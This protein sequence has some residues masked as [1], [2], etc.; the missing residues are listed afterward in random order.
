LRQLILIC[1]L[2]VASPAALAQ[3]PPPASTPGQLAEVYRCADESDA[4]QRLACYDAAVGRLKQA[5]QSGDFRA[6]D[7]EAVAS[8]RR[9]AFGFALPNLARILPFGRQGSVSEEIEQ[10]E[11]RQ[12]FQVDR[13]IERANGFH[14]FVMTNGQVWAQVESMSAR[15]MRSGANVTIRRAAFGSFLMVSERGG[16]AQRVRREQ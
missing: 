9:E 1:V 8:V 5:E 2:F 15:A 12:T 13:V 6:V 4:A 3:T 14:A 7:R 11:D 16:A 10:V